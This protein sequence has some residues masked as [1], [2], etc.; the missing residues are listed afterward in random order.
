[1]LTM[2]P[3]SGRTIAQQELVY[4]LGWLIH[5]RWIAAAG[6]VAGTALAARV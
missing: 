2:E 1:M 6:V 3:F 4:S 5:M